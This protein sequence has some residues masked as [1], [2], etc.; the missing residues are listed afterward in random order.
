MDERQMYNG[1][2]TKWPCPKTES[3]TN[4]QHATSRLSHHAF[5]CAERRVTRR[6]CQSSN[7]GTT[8]VLKDHRFTCF[9]FG[10]SAV[11]AVSFFMSI[12][13]RRNTGLKADLGQ[14]GQEL[15]QFQKGRISR[16]FH[17]VTFSPTSELSRHIHRMFT[18][19]R[20]RNETVPRCIT[21]S[22]LSS[23]YSFPAILSPAVRGQHWFFHR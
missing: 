18:I 5:F 20:Y 17:L 12:A 3:Y 1:Q 6:L 2:E 19:Y 4:S 11:Y 21:V 23:V 15:T 16:L 8:E 7:L 9:L 13:S 14:G 10:N 22:G